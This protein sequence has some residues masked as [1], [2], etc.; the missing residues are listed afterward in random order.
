MI[1]GSIVAIVTPMHE[2]GSLDLA[3]YR[4]LI[5]W[6]VASGTAAIVAVGTTGESPT[7]DVDEHAT[8]IRVAVEHAAGR[9]PVIAGTGGNSTREAIALTRHAAEVGAQA[10]LQVVPYYNKPGQEGL[11]RH[12]CAV[13]ESADLPVILY[14]VP[15]RTV[16]DLSNDTIVRLAE[17][18]GIVGLKDATGDMPRV[19]DLLS[20]VPASFALYSGNDDSALAL[21]ALGGHGVISVTANV[22]PR[23][24]A[25]LCAAALAGDLKSA[26]A[27]NDRL[28]PLHFKLFVEANPIPLKWALQR[29]GRIEGGIRLPMTPLE[30]RHHAVVEA[31]LRQSGV[32]A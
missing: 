23:E 22:A 31:A 18:P 17:V 19:S 6:H 4:A 28:L 1:T 24:M 5:D 26:R 25:A 3:R 30:P 16:A 12:F 27:I 32:L 2:D 8:L 15:G 14:N 20:R 9:V 11:Y 21:M 13:A 7:V 29:M 10:S